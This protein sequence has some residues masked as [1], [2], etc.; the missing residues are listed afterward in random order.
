MQYH[1][2]LDLHKGNCPKEGYEQIRSIF[3]ETAE[4]EKEPAKLFFTQLEGRDVRIE[5]GYP[6]GIAG[7][8]SENPQAAAERENIGW[9][10]QRPDF[11]EVT[12]EEE[13]SKADALFR[14]VAPREG[15]P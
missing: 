3:L 14:K 7:T 6:A 15:F 2:K 11:A 9:G 12:K 13:F 4:N 5:A 8:T 1:R 10:S